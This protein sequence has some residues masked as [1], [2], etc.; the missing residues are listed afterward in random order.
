MK[1][2]L[3]IRGYDG[4]FHREV[5][6]FELDQAKAL[7]AL[8]HDVKAIAMDVRSPIH[9]RIPG[10]YEYSLESIPVVYSSVPCGRLLSGLIEKASI[11]ALKRAFRFLERSGWTP[12]IVHAHFLGKGAAF[13]E[14]PESD[15]IP[16]VITEHA[17]RINRPDLPDGERER[18]K[19]VY[20]KARCVIAVGSALQKNLLAN[21]GIRAKV[22][23]NIVDVHTFP[24]LRVPEREGG[25]FHFV[26]V[27]RL[28]KGKGMEAL[29]E[30]MAQLKK[31]GREARL[32]IVGAGEEKDNLAARADALSLGGQVSF[33]G[34]LSREKIS[35]LFQRADAFVLASRSETFG[36]AYLEAMAAGLPVVATACG[37][38]ED[39]VSDKN[40][41]LVPVDD[42]D[43]LAD[44]MEHMMLHRA[45]YDSE[46]IAAE[47]REKYSPEKVAAQ[48]TAV[49]EEVLSC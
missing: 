42:K 16:F 9:L 31:R 14:L 20:E 12:D 24:C 3:I 27:G 44:A 2:L 23:P 30:A 49:Y 34:F 33:A 29:L 28:V 8:G 17:S 36:V 47:V 10:C 4:L 19:R 40:G 46:R 41:L 13:C 18:M 7:A 45:D 32:T 26:S 37:G 25:P 35:E 39:F 48:L 22:I 6:C 21:T 43:A 5:G 38:P 11:L 15:T 1:I